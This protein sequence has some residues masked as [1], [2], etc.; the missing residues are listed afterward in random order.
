MELRSRLLFTRV[1]ALLR[2]ITTVPPSV[3]LPLSDGHPVIH[4]G[5]G[6]P[7]HA[8]ARVATLD[9][10]ARMPVGAA[11]RSTPLHQSTG[12]PWLVGAPF[13]P[14]GAK[15]QG[16]VGKSVGRSRTLTLLQPVTL[17]DPGPHAVAPVCPHFAT[18]G[19]CVFQSTAYKAELK[20]KAEYTAAQFEEALGWEAWGRGAGKLSPIV[21]SPLVYGYRNKVTFSVGDRPWLPRAEFLAELQAERAAQAQAE[22]VGVQRP[23]PSAR[24]VAIG[25][26]PSNDAEGGFGGA[27]NTVLEVASCALLPAGVSAVLR[28]TR[29]AA[30]AW[31]ADA[32]HGPSL[33]GALEEVVVRVGDADATGLPTLQLCLRW[34]A[35]E[36]MDAL[37]GFIRDFLHPRVC[38]GDRPLVASFVSIAYHTS[39]PRSLRAAWAGEATAANP[40]ITRGGVIAAVERKSGEYL[41]GVLRVHH[42]EDALRKTYRLDG[43]AKPAPVPALQ[44]GSPAEG[45]AAASTPS[46]AGAAA[47]LRLVT[48]VSA[49]AFAQPNDGGAEAIIGVLATAARYARRE[50]GVSDVGGP[51]FVA[52]DLYCGAGVLGL[53]LAR[54][55]LVDRLVG[56]EMDDVSVRNARRNAEDNGLGAVAQFICGDLSSLLL[57]GKAAAAAA[58]PDGPA[59][60]ALPPPS[61]VVV[62]PPRAGLHPK[63]MAQLRSPALSPPFILYVSCNPASAAANVATLCGLHDGDRRLATYELLRVRPVDQFPHGSHVECVSLLRRVSVGMAAVGRQEAA[64][65]GRAGEA[66]EQRRRP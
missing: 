53:A 4:N 50:L 60:V 21:P 41:E 16:R 57:N 47:P 1:R 38:G 13:A 49:R 14:L 9:L 43:A 54:L 33:R 35:A 51:P 36:H 3:E 37:A 5:R 39:V 28:A 61:L 42:G 17:L 63:L 32:G 11:G 20:G 19:G 66:P 62:D 27:Y 56:V 40:G 24:G 2:S 26:M 12:K 55:G 45:A 46:S 25:L 34:T 31:E 29:E 8:S 23:A 10:L 30:S 15:V 44:D 59:G 58:E 52:W 65:A 6:A 64:P 48:T 18:C 7:I 22:H